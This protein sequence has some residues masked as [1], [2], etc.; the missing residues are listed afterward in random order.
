MLRSE[1]ADDHE[2]PYSEQESENDAHDNGHGLVAHPDFYD[3]PGAI[4]SG[5][6][7]CETPCRL[8]ARSVDL[9][10]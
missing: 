1:H 2:E 3:E 9:P 4:S 5:E 8:G 10:P 6:R 7:P